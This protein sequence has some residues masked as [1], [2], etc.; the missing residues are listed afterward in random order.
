MCVCA[1]VYVHVYVC[2][3]V[4]VYVSVC[5]C[6]HSN[7]CLCVCLYACL[8]GFCC[9]HVLRQS[10]GAEKVLKKQIKPGNC[11]KSGQCG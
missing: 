6:E 8:S 5:V 7:M 4:C 10:A 3:Y 2:V 1:C 11:A 9:R